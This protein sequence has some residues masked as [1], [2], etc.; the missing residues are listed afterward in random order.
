MISKLVL[1]LDQWEIDIRVRE[2]EALTLRG[3]IARGRPESAL[4]DSGVAVTEPNPE[5]RGRRPIDPGMQPVGT[6]NIK[7]ILP[8][9]GCALPCRSVAIAA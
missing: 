5:L 3:K 2:Q 7:T 4:Y 1:E 6:R 9:C 8:E